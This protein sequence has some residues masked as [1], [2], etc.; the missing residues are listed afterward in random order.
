MNEYRLQILFS[1]PTMVK[2]AGLL[3]SNDFQYALPRHDW[4]K[5]VSTRC[6]VKTAGAI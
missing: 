5:S 2:N 3:I 4:R 6:A 1:M